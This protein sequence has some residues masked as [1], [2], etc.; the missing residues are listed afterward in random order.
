MTTSKYLKAP[1]EKKLF[2]RASIFYIFALYV[3]PQY[4]GIPNPVF[5]L[6]IVRIAIIILLVFI[7]FDY[8]RLKDF[9]TLIVQEKM[10]L[11]M[12]P[13]IIVLLYTMVLR[14]DI[15]ALLNP[16]IEFLEMYLL[17]Y[18]I[19]ECVPVD[20]LIKII[21]VF[22]YIL[23]L[24]GFVEMAMKRSPFSYLETIKGVYTGQV[25]RNGNYRVMSSCVHSIGYGLL[26]VSAMP[27]VGIDLNDK[28]YNALK[29]PFL[30][31]G[32]IINIFATGSRSSLGVMLAE[33]L[34]MF[35]L[36]DK[37]YIKKNILI[38]FTSVIAF[39][40]ILVP[41][42]GTSIG[43]YIMLQITSLIDTLFG[44]ELSIKY[45]ADI[46][47]EQSADYRKLLQEVFHV[48]WLNPLLGLGRK[49]VFSTEVNGLAIDSIDN[50]YVAEYVRYA[51][52]GM[53]SYI[54]FLV[55]M[56]VSMLK[57]YIKTRSTIIKM[58][59]IGTVCFCLHLYIADSLQTLKYLYV[60]YALYICCDKK[61][62]V[63]ESPGRYFKKKKSVF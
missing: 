47:L 43:Q 36:S 25:I 26:L 44:T 62:Y 9:L 14:A 1:R 18:V 42:H 63:P 41:L 39:V 12:L 7:A 6:T 21:L 46:T 23:V 59:F 20:K 57:D 34:I 40:V 37:K 51:Y 28:S 5:D 13:Y 11:V 16:F 33:V 3:M 32:I 17:I 52:P 38:V 30:L 61:E 58:L 45:G 31:I 27:F 50:F 8:T 49:R 4:F 24:L 19:K 15:N 29:R 53:I 56:G 54:F 35:V 48:S 55:Y 2:Y 22:I 60:L 10:S